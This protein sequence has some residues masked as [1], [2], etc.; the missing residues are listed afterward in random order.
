[1]ATAGFALSLLPQPLRLRYWGERSLVAVGPPAP[2]TGGGFE[3]VSCLIPKSWKTGEYYMAAWTVLCHSSGEPMFARLI[4]DGQV[5]WEVR[6][7]TEPSVWYFMYCDDVFPM[8]STPVSVTVQVGRKVGGT[9]VVDVEWNGTTVPD[10]ERG[11]GSG[12][13][14][15]VLCWS[16]LPEIQPELPGIWLQFLRHYV[17]APPPPFSFVLIDLD[18]GRVL[19]SFEGDQPTSSCFKFPLWFGIWGSD[20]G[21]GRKRL[22][23]AFLGNDGSVFDYFDFEVYVSPAPTPT[24]TPTP[25]PPTPRGDIFRLAA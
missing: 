15:R 6:D 5:R 8:P 4:A 1:M 23:Y 12:Y 16:A 21:T 19:I 18:A 14:I 17:S 7:T 20:W 3:P 11:Q 10:G 9:D 13:P 25:T 24:P 2:A 22:R